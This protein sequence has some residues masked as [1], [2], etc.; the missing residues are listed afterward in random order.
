MAVVF[1]H[2]WVSLESPSGEARPL[3]YSS[4]VCEEIVRYLG[5]TW[6]G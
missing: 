5:R 1:F 2:G 4:K 6:V 3:L